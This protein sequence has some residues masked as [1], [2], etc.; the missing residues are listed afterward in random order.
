MPAQRELFIFHLKNPAMLARRQQAQ[1]IHKKPASLF[2]IT[3]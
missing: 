3:S 1:K 2:S